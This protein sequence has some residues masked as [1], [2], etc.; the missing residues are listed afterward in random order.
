MRIP[1]DV[2]LFVFLFAGLFVGLL[3]VSGSW[4]PEENKVS[5]SFNADPLGTKAF[6]TLLGERLG[7]N[8]RRLTVPLDRMPR[9]AKVLIVVQPGAAEVGLPMMQQM[10]IGDQE[11]A[12]VEKW[13]R[14]GGTLILAASDLEQMPGTLTRTGRLGSGHVY[15]YRSI[16]R[17]TNR[18]MRKPENAVE[19]ARIVARHASRR[20]PIFFDEYHHGFGQ[21]RNLWAMTGPRVKRSLAIF[22]AALALAVY[23][24]G[25]RFGAVRALPESDARRPAIEFVEA[26]GRLYRRAGAADVALQITIDSFLQRLQA[27]LAVGD[28]LSPSLTSI[29]AASAGQEAARTLE[30][31]LA[32]R[33]RLSAGYRPSEQELLS[34]TRDL[35]QMEK[36]L[37]LGRFHIQRR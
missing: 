13:V 32:V 20:D 24:Q 6:Y 11:A 34:I 7:F 30:R 9:N 19:M 2:W 14:R 29:V 21:S 33:S 4:P 27:R 18:G 16:N 3:V 35:Q 8:V 31:C 17:I 23:G 10:P 15:A 22:A 12:A 5:S 28:V 1:R 37:R 25:R 36:E 26:V